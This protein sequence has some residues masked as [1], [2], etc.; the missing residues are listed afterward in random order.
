MKKV[1]GEN[2]IRLKLLTLKLAVTEIQFYFIEH[3]VLFEW[4]NKRSPAFLYG[5]NRVQPDGSFV[6]FSI[7]Y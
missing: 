7:D 5:N 3:Y 4:N 6:C 2:R 1:K